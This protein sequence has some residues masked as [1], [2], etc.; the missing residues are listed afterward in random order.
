[1]IYEYLDKAIEVDL[2]VGGREGNWAIGEQPWEDQILRC[3]GCAVV[4]FCE[5]RKLRPGR[6]R[7]WLGDLA[8]SRVH[9]HSTPFCSIF[10]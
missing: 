4:S 5:K 6:R 8:P 10:I 3:Q 7:R 1:M 9:P 2:G